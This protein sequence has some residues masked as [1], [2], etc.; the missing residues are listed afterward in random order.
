M[1]GIE[2]H[3]RIYICLYLFIVCEVDNFLLALVGGVWN[4][5]F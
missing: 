4:L 3:E 5:I 2:E 1:F